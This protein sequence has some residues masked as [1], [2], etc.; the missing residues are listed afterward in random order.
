MEKL[1]E[2]RQE[3]TCDLAELIRYINSQQ[4]FKCVVG[5]DGEKHMKDS[6]HYEGLAHDLLIYRD[7]VWIEK[8][9]E[10][11]FA[12]DFWKGL[13]PENKWGGDFKTADGNHFSHGFY[14]RA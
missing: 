6:L 11:K 14:G 12:G 13:R 9:E 5:R 1:L 3:F 10:Y 2:A 8:T 7:G 4:G